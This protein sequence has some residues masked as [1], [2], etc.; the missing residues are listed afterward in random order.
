MR[1]HKYREG[2]K[3]TKKNH[4]DDPKF[5][6]SGNKENEGKKIS[7]EKV[8]KKEL[9]TKAGNRRCKALLS[10]PHFQA[11]T[12][13]KVASRQL[14][15]LISWSTLTR[16][17]FWRCWAFIKIFPSSTYNRCQ[18]W[19]LRVMVDDG[20]M[21]NVSMIPLCLSSCLTRWHSA[22][23]TLSQTWHEAHNGDA[24]VSFRWRNLMVK[25]SLRHCRSSVVSGLL[26]H[27]ALC[28]GGSD[29]FRDGFHNRQ[30]ICR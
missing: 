19:N 16:S 12:V 17:L 10:S 18:S 26:G 20:G 14:F 23:S 28:I 24:A 15:T 27:Q 22:C 25:V 3:I 4:L 30:N 5:W 9:T 13:L 2:I 11:S 29:Q 8:I 21:A 6:S 7:A 1:K